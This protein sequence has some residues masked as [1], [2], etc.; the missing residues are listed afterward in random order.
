MINVVI[1][2]ELSTPFP[3]VPDIWECPVT[4]IKVPKR[5]IE[6][7][8]FRAKLLRKASAD[9]KLQKELMF[10]SEVSPLAWFN[11]FCF[12]FVPKIVNIETGREINND[13]PHVPFITWEIQD[14]LITEIMA[15]IKEGR[16]L[17]IDKSRQ[18]GASW[19]VLAC[20][21]HLW[22]FRPD[23]KILELSRTESY[24]DDAGNMK[25]LFQK[26]D[27]INKW[28]PAWMCPPKCL[29]GGKYRRRMHLDNVLNGGAING[30]ATTKN[31]ARGD[32]RTV[33]LLDEFCV[34]E[35]GPAMRKATDDVAACRIINGTAHAGSEYSRWVTEKTT[36][37]F[38]MPWWEHPDK[39]RNRKVDYES[40]TKSYF[41]TS[42]WYEDQKKRR[43]PQSLAE[44][45]DM[46]H[47]GA[48]A[49]F[50]NIPQL[51]NY[52]L[53]HCRPPNSH[54]DLNFKK[55]TANDMVPGIIRS[56]LLSSV[57]VKHPMGKDEIAKSWALWT[58]LIEERPDQSFDVLL[59]ID[60]SKG[61]G[62]SDSVIVA[63]DEKTRKKLGEWASPYVPPHEFARIVTA[64]AIWWGGCNPRRLPYIIWEANGDPGIEFG[65]MMVKVLQ[66][67]YY[68][69]DEAM[70]V[71]GAPNKK[72]K[73]GF[74]SNTEKKA[75]LLGEYA[76][77]LAQGEIINY[78]KDAIQQAKT[79]ITFENGAVGPSVLSNISTGNLKA[80]GDKVIADA[81]AKRIM[82]LKF[83]K[84]KEIKMAPVGS[85]DYR[86]KQKLRQDKRKHTFAWRGALVPR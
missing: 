78:S 37:V 54:V 16:D 75:S 68:Y 18:M 29:P 57:T 43:D 39:G 80:H 1:K 32:T 51:E 76:Q 61:Q 33:I 70:G 56:R 27:Y 41:I 44:E 71:I 69:C 81:L 17:I 53:T 22:L 64:S 48:G 50:F 60:I 23:S 3:D 20:L 5:R 28:L 63:Y 30:E 67:P 24:V 8:D 59:G 38:T 4:G 21:H 14:R 26:H 62:A 65:R 86:R 58:P 82:K 55:G 19:I 84:R 47:Q 34:V 35:N 6:N 74:H 49:T 45:V 12:T 73:Y 11:I 85:F 36:K 72:K 42:P 52:E 15:C 66:Y 10:I 9:N 46:N 7:L 13:R 31:A 83:Q 40:F 77:A 25:A 2:P 79:Y